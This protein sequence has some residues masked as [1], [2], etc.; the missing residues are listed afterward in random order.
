MR[1]VLF[2]A[3]APCCHTTV[4]LELK[5]HLAP[6]FWVGSDPPTY[7]MHPIVKRPESGRARLPVGDGACPRC[8]SVPG[9]RA[10]IFP[11]WFQLS[12]SL[13][14][15]QPFD[16]EVSEEWQEPVDPASAAQGFS[17]PRIVPPHHPLAFS[18]SGEGQSQLLS[19]EVQKETTS[20]PLKT[21]GQ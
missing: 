10:A 12:S 6:Q 15:S 11:G 7:H 4:V 13:P 17:D 9:V 18:S 21:Q 20:A 3:R 2:T 19:Q 8:T 5:L 14:S 1:G 16:L